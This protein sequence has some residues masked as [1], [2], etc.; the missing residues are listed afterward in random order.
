MKNSFIYDFTKL[1]E[2]LKVSEAADALR[3][4]ESKVLQ[5]FNGGKL[6]GFRDGKLIRIHRES[7]IEYANKRGA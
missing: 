3:C 7:L 4:S 1:P 6:K 2:L 5:S